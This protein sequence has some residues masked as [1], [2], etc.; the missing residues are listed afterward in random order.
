[1]L[2][3]QAGDKDKTDAGWGV[4]IRVRNVNPHPRSWRTS[5]A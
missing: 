5:S 2:S 1:V 4:K 3:E